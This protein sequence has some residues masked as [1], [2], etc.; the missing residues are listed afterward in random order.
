MDTNDIIVKIEDKPVPA[1]F[2]SDPHYKESL[3]TEFKRLGENLVCK[4]ASTILGYADE[5]KQELIVEALQE[6]KPKDYV[7]GMLCTQLA[8]L[9]IMGMQ[10][11]NF[12][13]K[14]DK[15]FHQDPDLN[16][17]IKLMRLQHE[18]LEALSRYRRKGE[19]KVLVQHVQVNDGGKA[20][21]GNNLTAGGGG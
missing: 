15:R 1:R 9:H 5:T 14:T 2:E 13:M 19:Q 8:T 17:A 16:N 21:V 6:L 3:G 10:F 20:I 4:G 11:F 7:E 12:A 18:T